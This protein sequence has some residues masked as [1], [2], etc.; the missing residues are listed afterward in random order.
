MQRRL[1]TGP[2]ILAAVTLKT[3]EEITTTTKIV[4]N[5]KLILTDNAN[6]HH[7]YITPC[8]VFY[9]KTSVNM[10]GFPYLV[11]FFCDN[12][13]ATGTIAYCRTTVKWGSTKS[14]FIWDHGRHE[15]HFMHGSSHMLELYLYAPD[16]IS[17]YLIKCN[18]LV[19]HPILSTCI[20]VM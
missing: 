20:P 2:P 19:P 8:F 12:V 1:F 4:G 5:I 15:P 9:P 7:L 3:E 11:I 18:S 6:N 14:H 10:F 16:Y 17:F 13:D